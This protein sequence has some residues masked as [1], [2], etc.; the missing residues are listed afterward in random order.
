MIE[1]EK[2]YFFDVGIANYLARRVPLPGSYEFGKSFEHYILMELIAYKAYKKPETEITFWR[3]STRQEVDFLVN[4][5]ELAIEIKG[6]ARVHEGDIKGLKAL[7]EDGPVKR[8]V[9]VCL[10]ET[11]RVIQKQ[12]EIIPWKEF[13]EEL[14]NQ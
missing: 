5:K 4:D 11:R 3:T 12:I 6:S 9:V 2:F 1:T 13:L 10:E 14:W 8:A 7:L